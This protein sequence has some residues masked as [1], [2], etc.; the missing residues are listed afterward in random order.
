MCSC[1]S[2]EKE[3]M[4]MKTTNQKELR[5]YFIE[6]IYQTL[7]GAISPTPYMEIEE[8][9]KINV[10]FLNGKGELP[11][12][13]TT[14]ITVLD[15]DAASLFFDDFHILYEGVTGVGKTYTSDALFSSVFGNDGYTTLR[16][17]TGIMG[18]SALEPF[19]KT[20]MENGVPK[21]RI[22]HEKCAK[23]GALFIDEINRGD[24][25]E[26]LQ[27]VDGEIHINGDKGFLRVP[28]LST[29]PQR[30]KNLMV[31]AAMNPPD[32]EHKSATELDIAGENRFLKFRFP[33]GVDE[34][35]SSQ[36][37]KIVKDGLY[38]RFWSSFNKKA[39]TTGGW[40]EFYPVVTDSESL[41]VELNGETREFIDVALGY[42]G[43]APIET[44]EHNAELIKQGGITA[45]FGVR[46]D[47][48]YNKV[49]EAQ[50]LLKH[51]FV[52]R[53]LGKIG[54]LARLIG[55]IK[56][57]KNGSY[58]PSVNLNDV[59]VSMGVV[60]ESKIITGSEYGK[61][62]NLVNDARKAYTD[63]HKAHNIPEEYGF[64]QATWQAAVYAGQ[65]QGFTGYVNTIANSI[66][67]L[68][69]Q[70]T[71]PAEGTLKSRLVADL[72][73]LDHFSKTFEAD[74][75]K[76]LKQGEGSFQAFVDLYNE[77]KGQSS[78]YEHRLE[79]ILR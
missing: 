42:V 9:D 32:A 22:D 60:L 59:A 65:E 14:E 47:N 53:D 63:L 44:F 30:Y 72:V 43:H 10:K 51:G 2:L 52:R 79:S 76:I 77:K 66:N 56:S 26:V 38:D 5:K 78:I 1:T 17:S 74:I 55:F 40:R 29:S 70:T 39:G 62:I 7:S 34:A 25:Q 54:N 46:K 31:I 18:N 3:R 12:P 71:T 58:E 61:L 36:L 64:R 73:V 28:I 24:S 4:K 19:S 21:T 48:N 16:L 50:N 49:I 45:R 57:I 33:N 6:S 8:S 11:R 69:T 68:N 37:D 23:Y 75:T 15:I 13:N 67:A 41:Q 27:V 35:A 20:V